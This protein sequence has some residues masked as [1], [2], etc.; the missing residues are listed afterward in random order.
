MAPQKRQS[1]TALKDR[2]FEEYYRFSF[3]KA[4]DLLESLFPEKK[5]L[6]KTLVPGEEAVRFSVKPGFVFPP[7]DIS[8]LE[9]AD[10][11]LPVD[12]SVTFMGL[13]GPNAI[14]PQWYNEL[15]VERNLKKDFSLTAFLDLFHHRFISLFYLAWKKYRFPEN[16]IPGARDRLSRYMLSLA[17]LGTAGLSKMIGLPE[18]S[19]AFYSGLLSRGVPSAVAIESAVSYLAGVR[20]EIDQFI[21]QMIPLDAEDQTQIGAQ[22]ARLGVDAVCGSHIWDCQAKF[23]V[24]LGPMGYD[25]FL[26]FLPGGDMLGPIAALIKYMVGMEYEFELSI[27]LQREEIPPCIVGGATPP[28]LGLTTWIKSAGVAHESDPFITFHENDLVPG[29]RA[30][31]AEQR[32]H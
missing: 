6:G 14:L 17:G 7:S 20:A 24:N 3:F 26:R 31:L 22:N 4:V 27:I 30:F 13:V 11:A 21:E 29:G 5:A 15:A 10:D 23:R 2:L 12:M 9:Q 8:G 25:D 16:Y 18:E 1:G 28:Q 32:L 19:L